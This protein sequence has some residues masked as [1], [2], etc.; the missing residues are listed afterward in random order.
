MGLWR[1]L[2]IWEHTKHCDG[3]VFAKKQKGSEVGEWVELVLDSSSS[4]CCL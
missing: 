4:A 2:G 1:D 3:D